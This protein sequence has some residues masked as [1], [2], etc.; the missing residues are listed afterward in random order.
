MMHNKLG[1]RV[2]MRTVRSIHTAIALL[3]LASLAIGVSIAGADEA[4]QVAEINEWPK[5]FTARNYPIPGG[6]LSYS[7]ALPQN[8]YT[9][10]KN[11]AVLNPSRM[12]TGD[13]DEDGNLDFLVT[14]IFGE[15]GDP[16]SIEDALQGIVTP[17]EELDINSP[18]PLLGT[19]PTPLV[20]LF[21]NGEGGVREAVQ[22][23]NHT[24]GSFVTA[25]D[26]NGDGHLDIACELSVG[27][28][29]W[30]APNRPLLL[31]Y[32]DG[33]GSFPTARYVNIDPTWFVSTGHWLAADMNSDGIPDL[34]SLGHRILD[35]PGTPIGAAI[36]LGTEEGSYADARCVCLDDFAQA[37]GASFDVLDVDGDGDLDVVAAVTVITPYLL[38]PSRFVQ[39]GHLLT[40]E[41]DGTGGLSTDGGRMIPLQP[42]T[43]AVGD[44]N[45]D[46][47]EDIAV[48]HYADAE[49][50]ESET[51]GP[52]GE[53][54]YD[55]HRFG[56]QSTSATV[57]LG[58]GT[59]GFDEGTAYDMR[60]AMSRIMA[61]D[62]DGDGID[63]LVAV[64]PTDA[65]FTVR[66]GGVAGLGEAK[67]YEQRSRRQAYPSS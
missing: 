41:N 39:A 36:L 55:Y 17:L 23:T 37:S 56:G 5:T 4:S 3:L 16:V 11:L 22:L 13:F 49:I 45:G 47:I 59:R 33:L 32:G 43:V 6:V 24:N 50:T 52:N 60:V 30:E 1:R 58:D 18:W 12:E 2:T 20:L 48:S 44:F 42:K 61:G 31:L 21:G 67:L 9:E 51:L 46:G 63:D 64:S 15:L 54:L 25:A 29:D 65:R 38:D 66:L 35:T 53:T 40:L 19:W 28:P 7:D 10:L 27:H 14:T 26:L 8:Y 62:L 34:V 57:F